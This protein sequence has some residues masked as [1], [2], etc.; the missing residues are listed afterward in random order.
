MNY[1]YFY[2][3]ARG[4][5]CQWDW[6]EGDGGF[7]SHTIPLIPLI[8]PDVFYW[9]IVRTSISPLEGG[10]GFYSNTIPFTLVPHIF[11]DV[12]ILK[13]HSYF[14]FTA[15]RLGGQ[16]DP[17]EGDGGFYSNTIPFTATPCIFWCI[18]LHWWIIPI[19][20][21]PLEGVDVTGIR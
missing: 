10:G 11:S 19:S 9:W 12:F 8:F 7:Y 2:F 20:I 14:Y 13:K 3:T 18:Y 4:R 16:W 17:L 1:S 15:R 6:L 21:S 5:R